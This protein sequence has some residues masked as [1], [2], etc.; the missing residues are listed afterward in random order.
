[1][2]AQEKR[3]LSSLYDG[4]NAE[5]VIQ[6]TAITRTVD[7]LMAKHPE[8]RIELNLLREQILQDAAEAMKVEEE[9]WNF[10]VEAAKI[11]QKYE[12]AESLAEDNEAQVQTSTQELREQLN[13]K[14]AELEKTDHLLGLTR[15]DRLA[16]RCENAELQ[17]D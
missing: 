14:N 7:R 4:Q 3:K 15:E 12:D 9:L 11:P 17:D 10:R 6:G 13:T 16:L 1:M 2:P 8:L 5:P